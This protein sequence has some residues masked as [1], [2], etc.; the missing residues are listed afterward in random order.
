MKAAHVGVPI[1]LLAGCALPPP[2]AGDAPKWEEARLIGWRL[3]E[4]SYGS[5]DDPWTSALDGA[6]PPLET[7]LLYEPFYER[8]EPEVPEPGDWSRPCDHRPRVH[9]GGSRT[10]PVGR[11]AEMS[12]AIDGPPD[13]AHMVA[14]TGTHGGVEILHVQGAAPL[15]GAPGRFVLPGGATATV[16]FTSRVAGRGGVEVAV[17]SEG[18]SSSD[19]LNRFETR[20]AP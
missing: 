14:L 6:I 16:A 1:L 3:T 19:T 12:F 10:E 5:I 7:A 17:L 13:A 2:H 8:T 20:F 9:Y 18:T 15:A 11:R 4:R